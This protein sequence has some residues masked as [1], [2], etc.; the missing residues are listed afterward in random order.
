MSLDT[1]VPAVQQSLLF[2][3]ETGSGSAPVVLLLLLFHAIVAFLE[4]RGHPLALAPVNRGDRVELFFLE[5][6]YLGSFLV[7]L[8]VDL[9]FQGV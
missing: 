5:D 2:L 9:L 6:V 4:E 7:V 1:A 3:R 8:I